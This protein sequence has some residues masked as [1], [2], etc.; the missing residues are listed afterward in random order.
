[1]L[2]A[3]VFVAAGL[4]MIVYSSM[5][6]A[7][8]RVQTVFGKLN[9]TGAWIGYSLPISVA[10]NMKTLELKFQ[11]VLPTVAPSWY[12]FQPDNCLQTL[13]VNGKNV[14]SPVIPFCDYQY[15]RILDLG[16]YLH[17]GDNLVELTIKNSAGPGGFSFRPVPSDPIVFLPALIGVLFF[18][19]VGFLFIFS[20]HFWDAR[21]AALILFGA[22][23]RAV[24]VL[25][26]SFSTRAYDWLGHFEYI[27]YVAQHWRIPAAIRGWEFHQP[28]LY[29]LLS[30]AEID[31]FRIAHL[32]QW[33]EIALLQ[34]SSLCISIVTLVV[35]A[36][37]AFLLF[38]AKKQTGNRRM[39]IGLFAVLPAVV[40][41]ASRINNDILYL[42]VGSL[43]LALL[44]RWWESPTRKRWFLLSCVLG[45]GLLTK[46]NTAVFVPITLLCLLVQKSLSV[47]EK[48]AMGAA[49]LSIIVLLAGWLPVLRFLVENDTSASFVG[50]MHTLSHSFF[51]SNSVDQF[52]N[53]S[54]LRIVE[55]PYA[56]TYRDVPPRYFWE[57]FFR[58]ALIGEFNLGTGVLPFA[59]VLAAFALMLLPL[60]LVGVWRTLHIQAVRTLPLWLTAIG[61]LGAHVFLR[62]IVP[63]STFQDFRYSAVLVFPVIYFILRG[64]SRRSLV[65]R[66]YCSCA[67][68]GFIFASIALLV[69]LML[70]PS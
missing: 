43:F 8:P 58:S 40:F 19:L 65:G 17:P 52:A 35:A 46:N 59:R 53:F 30:A 25:C 50:N 62:L 13:T 29:Y 36:W 15:G 31:L 27:S 49:S 23:L 66:I 42:L 70:R 60:L 6:L 34:W 48:V 18:V 37:I 47:R 55:S 28:P 21:S 67:L 63:S 61:V 57:F 14:S 24:Y 10:S 5:I 39:L 4:V 26:T 45:L 2:L 33:M 16:S 22:A 56:N 3:S 41:F 68:Y 12:H 54:P 32:P 69:V 1:M 44:L 51:L 38:P 64:R 9:G 20:A 7:Q 11:L